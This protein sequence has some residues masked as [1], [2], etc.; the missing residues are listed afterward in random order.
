MTFELHANFHDKIFVKDFPLSSILLEDNKH[1]PWFILVPKKP[2]LTKLMDLSLED[3][4]QLIKEID[5]VQRFLWQ[6]FNPKQLNVAA[7]GNKTPQL[8]IHVIARFE[9]DPAWPLTVWDQP[10][11]LHYELEE[12]TDLLKLWQDKLHFQ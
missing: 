9:C 11:K 8:H 7:I 3:Q 5:A 4:F 2:G 6:E 10:F 12:K 1:Y